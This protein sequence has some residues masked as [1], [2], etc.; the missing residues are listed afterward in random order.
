MLENKFKVLVVEET[1]TS[2]V[3]FIINNIAVQIT[4]TWA[5]RRISFR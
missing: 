1:K 2:V 3:F 4:V 5:Q